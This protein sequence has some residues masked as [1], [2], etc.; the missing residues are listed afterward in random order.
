MKAFNYKKGKAVIRTLKEPVI[1]K[2][3][4]NFDRAIYFIIIIGL[5]VWL[6]SFIYN[7]T[8]WLEGNGQML[9]EKVDVNFTND[10]RLK[11]IF[12]NEGDTV[13]KGSKLFNYFQNDF[14]SDAS[15]VL[16]N[17]DRKE[18]QNNSLQELERQINNKKIRLRSLKERL[19]FL[20]TQEKKITKLVLLDVYTKPKLDDLLTQQMLL[21]NQIQIHRSELHFLLE[22]KKLI[23][24]GIPLISTNR[25]YQ[26]TYIS[27]IKGVVGQI[28]KS[29]EEACYKTENVLTIHNVEKVFIKAYFD[30]KDLSK[31]NK[32]DIVEVE[33]PD[34]TI[35]K[36]IINKLYIAT[37][38]APTEFQKKYEPTERNILT[39][40][41]PLNK[42]Q[43][44]DWAK[45]YKLNLKIK[46]GKF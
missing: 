1:K 42:E 12:I 16:K 45:F 18:K 28:L 22:D 7:K 39:E 32:G 41:V 38:K 40:I 36:G 17:F 43:I 10:V 8:L 11:E 9:M 13:S 5:V 27:P 19:S 44:P 37:Y 23:Q 20:N 35:S 4:L 6:S 15:I 2:K 34:K 33:F 25:N 26:N 3:K 30:L 14:D 24:P 21:K 46:V 31:I 29:S